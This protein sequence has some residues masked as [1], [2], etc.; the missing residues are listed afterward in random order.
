MICSSCQTNNSQISS[1]CTNCGSQLVASKPISQPRAESSNLPKMFLREPGSSLYVIRA[2]SDKEMRTGVPPLDL[3][4]FP[5]SEWPSLFDELR[6]IQ[7]ALCSNL[8]P[9][10]DAMVTSNDGFIFIQN[11]ST[12]KYKK[13]KPFPIGPATITVQIPDSPSGHGLALD[14]K[15]SNSKEV[16]EV[17]QNFFEF[18]REL[19]ARHDWQP[20]DDGSGKKNQNSHGQGAGLAAA[21]ITTYFVTEEFEF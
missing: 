15:V 11:N 21:P 5:F 10:L 18:P 13:N 14:L 8:H 12:M 1:T 6:P 20:Y 4:N 9:E 16:A 7:F 2:L 3:K 17:A 19:L